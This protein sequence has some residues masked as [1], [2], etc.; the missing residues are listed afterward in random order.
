MMLPTEVL[1]VTV[2]NATDP[3]WPN[4]VNVTSTVA[5]VGSP[6]LLTI[7]TR[8]FNPFQNMA[9]DVKP[10]QVLGLLR[11]LVPAGV[12]VAS[13]HEGI[14]GPHLWQKQRN[15]PRVCLFRHNFHAQW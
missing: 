4:V 1:L 3:P 9:I 11:L 6:L 5:V 14:S 13:H 7:R 2:G 10:V 8:S 15:P 12:C